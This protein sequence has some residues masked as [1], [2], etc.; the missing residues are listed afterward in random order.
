MDIRIIRREGKSY[1]ALEKLGGAQD[2]TRVRTFDA[3]FEAI[4]VGAG[5]DFGGVYF[6]PNKKLPTCWSQTWKIPGQII[7]ASAPISKAC[8]ELDQR[9]REPILDNGKL[10]AACPKFGNGCMPSIGLAI[11]VPVLGIHLWNFVIVGDEVKGK[12]DLENG[13]YSFMGFYKKLL[14]AHGSIDDA[15]KY[16]VQIIY[17]A[18]KEQSFIKVLND[19]DL[20]ED[21]E[22]ARLQYEAITALYEQAKSKGRHL[23]LTSVDP[24]LWAS[25][26]H[27]KVIEQTKVIRQ[28]QKAELKKDKPKPKTRKKKRS[29]V[30][31]TNKGRKSLPRK[32]V[33]EMQLKRSNLKPETRAK[34]EAELKTLLAGE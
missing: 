22:Q 10:V 29:N 31:R 4:I 20:H 27:P 3:S 30:K 24:H 8:L 16:K 13:L 9:T 15:A 11:M 25:S 23:L 21:P 6:D 26:K 1:V 5:K 32:D 2:Y 28:K 33:L 18:D 34:F 19:S 17:S 7:N 12:S 14:D